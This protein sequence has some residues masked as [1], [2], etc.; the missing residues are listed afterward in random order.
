[1]LRQGKNCWNAHSQVKT[2]D[3]EKISVFYQLPNIRGLEMLQ[4]VVIGG[5]EIG[6]HGPVM[7][8]DHDTTAPRRVVL[9]DPVLGTDSLMGAACFDELSG[10]RIFSDAPNING[11][12]RREHVL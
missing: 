3:I 12:S 4:L 2:A 11:R 8:S 6:D 10:R 7:A 1:M 9:V 5:C